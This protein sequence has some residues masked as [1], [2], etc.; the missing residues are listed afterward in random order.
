MRE[1]KNANL[2]KTNLSSFQ[3]KLLILLIKM[4]SSMLYNFLSN[5]FKINRKLFSQIILSFNN[6]VN[7]F[8]LEVLSDKRKFKA[9][10]IVN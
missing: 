7:Y 8:I 1:Y 4:L 3:L 2:V 9:F 10:I 5:I 6:R